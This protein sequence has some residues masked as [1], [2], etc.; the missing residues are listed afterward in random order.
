MSRVAGNVVWDGTLGDGDGL[1]E[2][3]IRL[4]RKIVDCD[5]DS[6]E[7]GGAKLEVVDEELARRLDR[8]ED[9][10]RQYEELSAQE[11]RFLEVL[12]EEEKRIRLEYEETINSQT[13]QT[14]ANN[15]QC[16]Q[17]HP[18]IHEE[19]TYSTIPPIANPP[20]HIKSPDN[21]T[22]IP[23][24]NSIIPSTTQPDESIETHEPRQL[25]FLQELESAVYSLETQIAKEQSTQTALNS[26]ISSSQ[27]QKSVLTQHLTEINKQRSALEVTFQTVSLEL[28]ESEKM[29][30]FETKKSETNIILCEGLYTQLT[31][32]N[33]NLECEVKTCYQRVENSKCDIEKLKLTEI[34]LNEE[35]KRQY[36]EIE[37]VEIEVTRE[38]ERRTNLKSRMVEQGTRMKVEREERERK[39]SLV[40]VVVKF[41]GLCRGVLLR[42]D[43]SEKRNAVRVI[44]IFYKRYKNRL[45]SRQISEKLAIQEQMCLRIQ[46]TWRGYRVRKVMKEIR[47]RKSKYLRHT[48]PTSIK[49]KID[50]DDIEVDRI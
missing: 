45:L 8:E 41:Q 40:R 49:N 12:R 25:R 46:K 26:S 17:L 6:V 44:R 20:G 10:I 18:L 2:G 23:I 38:L 19:T 48:N 7:N 9:K 39:E 33:Q 36:S 47:S 13:I 22:D 27:S 21:T 30:Q 37:M 5:I 4:E 31:K 3:K 50:P 15:D 14:T 32:L 34:K 16:I 29:V 35:L 43:V 11:S 24:P 28:E 42:R 1:V